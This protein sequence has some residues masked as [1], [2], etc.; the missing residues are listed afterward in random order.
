MSEVACD[1]PERRGPVVN[2]A[3]AL[4]GAWVCLS[5]R[6][7]WMARCRYA[8]RVL[9]LVGIC[10]ATACGG[11]SVTAPDGLQGAY[12]GE[13]AGNT[14]Q[15]ASVAFSVSAQNIVTSITIGHNFSGCRDTQMFSGLSVP[16][17]ESGF[18]GR[19]AHALQARVRIWIGLARS[20]ELRAND[21][22]VHVEPSSEWHGDVPQL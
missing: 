4:N 22:A 13:W 2:G 1:L 7:P 3:M 11:G 12:T 18:P 17:G 14:S 8:L 15:G 19:V 21:W 10:G 9:F 6:T 5:D 16:I 20:A